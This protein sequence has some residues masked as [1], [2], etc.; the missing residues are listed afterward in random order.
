MPGKTLTRATDHASSQVLAAVLLGAWL[1]FYPH[2]MYDYELR[3]KI[4]WGIEAASCLGVL[5]L[6]SAR[7]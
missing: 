5:L 1:L 3:F 6:Y 4:I 7:Q 2:H